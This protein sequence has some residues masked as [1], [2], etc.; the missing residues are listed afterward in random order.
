MSFAVHPGRNLQS[1]HDAKS[2]PA[3]S[4]ATDGSDNA[5]IGSLFADVRLATV[6]R[7]NVAPPSVERMLSIEPVNPCSP[8]YAPA[9]VTSAPS[10]RTCGCVPMSTPVART[11]AD[12]VTPPSSLHWLV[13]SVLSSSV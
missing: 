3:P 9:T 4:T 12:H 11:G 8:A 6:E 2:V 7:A 13:V 1:A 10:G 5:R